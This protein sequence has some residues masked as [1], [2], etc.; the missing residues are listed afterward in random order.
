MTPYEKLKLKRERNRLAS[1]KCRQKKFDNIARYEKRL[2]EL[3]QD[4]DTLEKEIKAM[5]EKST[6]LKQ[7]YLENYS[8]LAPVRISRAMAGKDNG[9]VYVEK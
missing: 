2:G 8:D 1:K 7:I 4:T 5:R 9:S 6:R 3:Q